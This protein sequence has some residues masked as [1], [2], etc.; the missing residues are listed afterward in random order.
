MYQRLFLS[1][2]L[3][4]FLTG[5]A[6]AGLSGDEVFSDTEFTDYT[7]PEISG[8]FIIVD[9]SYL[10]EDELSGSA[11]TT[12]TIQYDGYS[13][14]YSLNENTSSATVTKLTNVTKNRIDVVVPENITVDNVTYNVTGIEDTAF[15]SG[16]YSSVSLY[17]Y[18]SRTFTYYSRTDIVSVDCP[19]V[20]F[21]EFA[22]FIG[23]VNLRTV[24]CPNVTY[25]ESSS[26]EDCYVLSSIDLINVT[27]IEYDAF[28]HCHNL[29]SANCPNVTSIGDESFGYCRNLTSVNCPN[30]T[31]IDYGAFLFCSNL[32]EVNIS[33]SNSFYYTDSFALFENNSSG[34]VL[35]TFLGKNESSYTTPRDV[36]TIY[37]A[38]TGCNNLTSVSCPNVTTIKSSAF[39]SCPNLVSVSCPNVITI[40]PGAFRNCFNLTDII[41]PSSNPYYFTDSS[42][43]FENNTS[44]TVLHTFLGQNEKYYTVPEKV[45]TIHSF[46]FLNCPNITSI[47]CSDV[48]TI[49]DSAFQ[50]CSNLTSVDCPNVTIINSSAFQNCSNLTSVDCPNVTTINSS[51]FQNCSNLVSVDFPNVTTINSSAFQNCSN[52]T[53]VSCPNVT[54]IGSNAFQNCSNLTFIDCPNVVTIDS[55]VFYNCRNI[56][57]VSFLNVTRLGSEVFYNCSNLTSADCPNVTTI[58]SYAFDRCPNLTT[59]VIKSDFKPPSYSRIFNNCSNLT[60]IY[61][62]GPS[63]SPDINSSSLFYNASENIVYYRSSEYPDFDWQNLNGTKGIFDP[64][65]LHPIISFDANGGTG[66]TMPSDSKLNGTAIRLPECS[67]TKNRS[68]FLYWSL[69]PEGNETAYYPGDLWTVS[70]NETFYARWSRIPSDGEIRRADDMITG[71]VCGDGL[72]L[73]YDYTRDGI[74][75]GRD[76]IVY[77]QMIW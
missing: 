2:L 10:P 18:Y 16:F 53:S 17:P 29:A 61:F 32:T 39:H 3:I 24:N 76:L 46:A 68:N 48:T 49:N 57:F 31:S 51:A 9:S 52:I 77:Q 60:A 14:N 19:S 69:C 28:K 8:N 55:H 70:G 58:G 62:M 7:E 33:K 34:I 66:P 71:F 4:F 12:A 65:E 27:T 20:E 11:S 67:Y 59:V 74:V 35:H 45:M 15:A 42:A 40:N 72:D 50:N 26:F 36:T 41:I 43:L 30:V 75:D 13:L 6:V 37:Y 1:I 56:T 38:F 23:C 73:S 47:D 54:S 21:L 5:T 63:L 22:S 44:G 64:E 25:I